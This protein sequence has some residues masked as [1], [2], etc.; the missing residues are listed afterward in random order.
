[1]Y[2]LYYNII[3]VSVLT[4]FVFPVRIESRLRVGWLGFNSRPG[5]WCH[6]FSFPP[7]PDRLWGPYTLLSNGYQGLL[8][9]DKAASAGSY[10]LTTIL[11][12]G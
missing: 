4:V 8:S 3:S 1:M 6:F 12:R 7:P 10:Q 2:L 5:K 9:R 11:C